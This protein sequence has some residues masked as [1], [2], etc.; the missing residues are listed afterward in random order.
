MK[1]FEYGFV[2]I[3][4]ALQLPSFLFRYIMYSLLKDGFEDYSETQS[5]LIQ[6]NY[7][8]LKISKL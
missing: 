2:Q 1:L 4:I 8:I 5:G 7:V 6:L 3:I